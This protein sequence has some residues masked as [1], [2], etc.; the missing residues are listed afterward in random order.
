MAAQPECANLHHRLGFDAQL[1]MLAQH[2]E[3]IDRVA[4]MIGVGIE[5]RARIGA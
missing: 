5:L 1:F 4:K 2:I 3:M